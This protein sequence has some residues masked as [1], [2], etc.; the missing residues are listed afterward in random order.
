M[1]LVKQSSYVAP[2]LFTNPH[3][4]TIYPAIFRQTWGVRYQRVRITT[5]DDDFLDLDWSYVGSKRLA[6]LTHGLEG[7]SKHSYILGMVKALNQRGVT[8]LAWN[9]RGCSGELNR[10]KHFYHM[11]FSDDLETVINHVKN[12]FDEIYLIG[13]SLGGNLTLKYLGQ[14]V[15]HVPA[16]IKSAVAFS[17]PIDLKSC[18][19]RVTAHQNWFYFRKFMWTIERKISA[20]SVYHHLPT[21]VAEIRNIA[22]FKELD[23]LFTAPLFGFENADEL[24][25]DSSSLKYLHKIRTPALL[26]TAADDPLLGS[27][28]YPTEIA[29]K[30]DYFYFERPKQGG[31]VGFVSFNPQNEY[32]SETRALEFMGLLA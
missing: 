30:S 21:N 9:L 31:H 18:V 4:Q 11:G 29:Q 7:H 13:F 12:N 6:I 24:W 5:P 20:K 2:P 22:S 26:V 14:R 32:W 8:A 15:E 23:D 1:P 28:C 17:A 10:K 3:L 25:A 27:E 19:N 16:N